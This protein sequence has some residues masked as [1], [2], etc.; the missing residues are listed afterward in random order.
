[1]GITVYLMRSHFPQAATPEPQTPGFLSQTGAPVFEFAPIQVIITYSL[2]NP[3]DGV[4]FIVPSD[5]YPYVSGLLCAAY[6]SYLIWYGSEFHTRIR[7]L[8]LLTLLGVGF[9]V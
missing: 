3:A 6:S 2:R 1:M 4:Q 8:H 9:H 7:L 5:A